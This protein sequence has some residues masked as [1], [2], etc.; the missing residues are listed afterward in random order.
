VVGT[1]RRTNTLPTAACKSSVMY[2]AVCVC[3]LSLWRKFYLCSLRRVLIRSAPKWGLV[4]IHSVCLYC[5]SSSGFSA[6]GNEWHSAVICVVTLSITVG[7]K[8]DCLCLAVY[9]APFPGSYLAVSEILEVSP[10]IKYVTRTLQLVG[11]SKL[12]DSSN[13]SSSHTA[14]CWRRWRG[15]GSHFDDKF[16]AK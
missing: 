12:L 3:V 7:L 11:P 5:T 4:C 16:S 8:N 2:T 15:G 14:P 13:R 1:A 6:R 9:P 10:G